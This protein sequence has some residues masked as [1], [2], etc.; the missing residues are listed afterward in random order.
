MYGQRDGEKRRVYSPSE[1]I[2]RRL[3][4]KRARS[5]DGRRDGCGGTRNVELTPHGSL[6]DELA[7]LVLLRRLVGSVCRPTRLTISIPPSIRETTN[8]GGVRAALK[9]DD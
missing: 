2:G 3:R 6:E 4:E 7:L 8:R 5:T 1:A 9:Y